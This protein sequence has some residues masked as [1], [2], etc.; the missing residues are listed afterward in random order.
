MEEKQ[1]LQPHSLHIENRSRIVLTGVTD[2]GSFDESMVRLETSAGSL[3][4]QGEN[5]QVTKL[6]LE[7]GDITVDGAVNAVSYAASGGRNVGFFS[8]VFG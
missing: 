4:I 7:S 1:V 8:K 6:S 5:L 3:Q 2:V